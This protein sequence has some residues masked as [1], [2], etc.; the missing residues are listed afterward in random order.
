MFTWWF[1]VTVS[2]LPHTSSQPV[3]LRCGTCRNTPYYIPFCT[4]FP[5][6][7]FH[8]L[9]DCIFPEICLIE[10]L[11]QQNG[12]ACYEDWQA[13]WVKFFAPHSQRAKTC[14]Q[15]V[16]H[17]SR[18]RRRPCAIRETLERLL[19]TTSNS[20]IIQSDSSGFKSVLLKRT[21]SRI[22]DS[23][24]FDNLFKSLRKQGSV[25]VYT[26]RESVPKTIQMFR[27]ADFLVGYHGAGLIN[28]YFMR[29]S[30]RILEIST[31]KDLNNTIPWKSNM[32]HVTKYGEFYS[33]VLRIPLQQLL[34]ANPTR[35][36]GFRP[37]NRSAVDPRHFIKNLKYVR[38]T[39]KDVEQ[40]VD[41]GCVKKANDV[42]SG[43]RRRRGGWGHGQRGRIIAQA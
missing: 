12:S 40:I 13:H 3:D 11:H 36:Y 18:P 29:N 8:R 17:G 10:K 37:D 7:F 41:F 15:N 32:K 2:T 30:T 26:G 43:R 23:E 1:V 14:G 9:H 6:A 39:H 38:L 21:N 25:F 4:P 42:T 27:S 20:E 5:G 19:R 34:A 22:F 35:R 24:S 31:Y 28:A 33:K 16:I